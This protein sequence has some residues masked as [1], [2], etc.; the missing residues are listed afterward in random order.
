M[1]SFPCHGGSGHRYLKKRGEPLLPIQNEDYRPYLPSPSPDHVAF[2][3]AAFRSSSRF[4]RWPFPPIMAK[5]KATAEAT[6][7]ELRARAELNGYKRGAY[8]EQ[9]NTRDIM[10]HNDDT[11]KQQ[12]RM[13]NRYII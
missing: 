9:D 4:Q 12:K 3:P 6:A 10:K 7:E 2:F 1:G 8:R 13:L 11:K 5:R